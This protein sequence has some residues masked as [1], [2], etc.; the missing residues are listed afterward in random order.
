[1]ET[2]RGLLALMCAV[3]AGAQLQ[4]QVTTFAGKFCRKH[5]KE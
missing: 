1:M 3:A 4:S 2:L 5:E